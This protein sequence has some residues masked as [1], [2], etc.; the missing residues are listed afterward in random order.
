MIDSEALQTAIEASRVRVVN[1]GNRDFAILPE[2]YQ[3]QDI[4]P[5]PVPERVIARNTFDDADSFNRY[6]NRH[7]VPGTT[8]LGDYDSSKIIAALDYH[9]EQNKVGRA[10]H[11]AQWVLRFSEA[12]NAWRNFEG[13]LHTQAEFL[14]F[15]EENA[16]TD[17]LTPTPGDVL[18]FVR[19][20]Q[21][22]K[23][24]DFKSSQR[25]DNGDRAF[26]FKSET[27]VVSAIEVPKIIQI[28]IPIYEGEAPVTV[29]CLFR[30]RAAEGEL[31][32]GYEFHRIK[33]T[34]RNAFDDA[35]DTVAQGVELNVLAGRFSGS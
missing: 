10:G 21:A 22:V 33:Q 16:E 28:H 35:R 19:D 11:W 18:D 34:L 17:I 13:K 26:K 27:N 32:L 4:T 12:F 9:E 5:D 14:R 29:D 24:E 1:A 2:G 23:S 3:A 15:L 30:Y 31:R 7:K 6:V 25:L 8:I 20:F